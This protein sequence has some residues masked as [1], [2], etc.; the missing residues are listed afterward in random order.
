MKRQSAAKVKN[1]LSGKIFNNIKILSY[2]Y[3]KNS[4][5]FYNIECL[6]CGKH[7]IMRS[8][9]LTSKSKLTTCK[10]CKQSYCSQKS[11]ERS[12]INTFYNCYYSSY[13]NNALTRNLFFN[14]KLKE[15][16]KYISKNCYYCGTTPKQGD[17]GKY[18]S[19][20]N[21][22]VY[23][24]GI[25]RLDSSLGYNESNIVTCCTT[26][27]MMKKNMSEKEFLLQIKKIFLTRFND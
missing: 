22:K 4:R 25:D 20:G 5:K 9:N 16:I 10:H 19:R 2:A 23:Y 15:F 14:M 6:N 21:Y 7:S 12:N 18:I 26:C 24:N 3:H 17:L 11:K 8:D 1:N 27:N 13:K